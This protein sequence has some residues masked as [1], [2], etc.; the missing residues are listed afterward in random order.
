MNIEL[1]DF[2]LFPSIGLT[3]FGYYCKLYFDIQQDWMV[4]SFYLI[5]STKIQVNYHGD[6]W[7]LIQTTERIS[8]AWYLHSGKKI[9]G[10]KPLYVVKWAFTKGCG[11]R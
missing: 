9:S 6:N 5:N 8:N 3:S 10:Q 4:I 7:L 1:H 11:I 2:Q